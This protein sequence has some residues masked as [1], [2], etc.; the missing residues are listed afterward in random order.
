MIDVL[1][2]DFDRVSATRFSTQ[3]SSIHSR[4]KGRCEGTEGEVRGGGEGKGEERGRERE[5][6]RRGMVWSEKGRR[7]GR[8][9]RG[10]GGGGGALIEIC[11]M[12][13]N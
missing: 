11:G 10:E 13:E 12:K 9:G 5:R 8:V 6:E 3:V 4:R 7:E 1:I 2:V